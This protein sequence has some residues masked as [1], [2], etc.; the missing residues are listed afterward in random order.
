MTSDPIPVLEGDAARAVQHRGSHLQIIASAGSGKTEVVSQ[1]VVDLFATGVEPAQVLAFTFTERAAASLKTRIEQRVAGRL[2]EAFLDRLNGCFVGTIHAYCFRLLQQHVPRYETYDVLDEHRL[3]A[4]LTREE[5]RIGFRKLRRDNKLFAAIDEFMSNIDVVENELVPLDDLEEPFAGMARRFY[6]QL[7]QYR[8]LTYGQLVARAVDELHRPAVFASVHAGL[9]HLIVDEYQDVNPA[10]ER[11][12]ALLA[13]SPVELCVV[14]DDDQSIYQWRGSDVGNIVT[15]ADRYPGV[16]RF[17][18]TTNRRSRPGII[19][20]AN[21]FAATIERRL[22]KTMGTWRDE[23]PVEGVFWR[24]PTEA[25]EAEVIAETIGRMRAEGFRYRDI[26]VLVRASTSYPRLLEAFERHGIPVQPAGRTGLFVTD[27]AKR[28]GRTF[29]FIAGHDWRPEPYGWG[30]ETV[31]LEGLVD[32]YTAGFDLDA[33]GRRRVRDRLQ[34]WR[35]ESLA[36][37]GPANLVG[38]YYELLSDCGVAG[39]D[40]ADPLTVARLGALARCSALLADYECVRRRARPDA[41]VAGEAVGGQDRGEWYFKWLAIHIQNWAQ[42][43]FEGFDGEDDVNLDAV[44]LT[45]I[46]QAKGLEW[47]VVFVPCLSANRF[48]SSKTGTAKTWHLPQRCFDS[49]RYEGTV[50]DERRLFYVAMTRARDWLSLSTHDTPKKQA[51]KPSPF[52]VAVVGGRPVRRTELS[53]PPPP[54]ESR[55]DEEELLGITFSELAAFARCGLSYRL[56]TLIGFQPA[57]AP[58]LGYG[59]A[60]HHV[61]REVAEHTRRRA[62]APTP[63]ELDRLFDDHFFLPAANK[64]AHREMKERAR[65]LV[66]RYVERYGDDLRRVWAVERPFE[67]HL[68][69]AIVSGRADVILDQEDGRIESLAI[70]DYKTRADGAADFDLQLQVYTDAGRREGLEVRAAYVHDLAAGDRLPVDV[71]PTTIAAAEA[72]VVDLVDRLRRRDFTPSP[73]KKTCRHCDVRRICPVAV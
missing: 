18:I 58:E 4:F 60:V 6:A 46:H 45:T 23:V 64:A 17:S 10:Q 36:P 24:A 73:A 15:F 11:L 3:A 47:P 48:P 26:A 55:S 62:A 56:R 7:Q 22:D 57:L 5:K 42:G 27:D 59:K 8:F 40:L 33:A 52:L 20:A 67:L 41:A 34:R 9:R 70:V 69:S 32:D 19:E 12:V 43:A 71:A 39:W 68:P 38:D 14:G 25:D 13:A 16:E 1:R 2:G 51:V 30:G 44:D 37:T 65:A 21:G 53:L 31:T 61:L 49:T 29:A 50:N 54:P 66:D 35:A 63:A 72:R 28:F